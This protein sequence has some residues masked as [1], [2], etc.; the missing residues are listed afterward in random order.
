MWYGKHQGVDFAAQQDT[1][2]SA[3]DEGEVTD[4]NFYAWG[5]EV[6]V[7]MANG[8]TQRYLHMDSLGVH[9]GQHIGKGDYIG[10]TGGGTPHSGFGYWSRG[11]HLHT[12]FDEGNINQGIDPWS[13]WALMGTTN[14]SQYLGGTLSTA[15]KGTGGAANP[16][17]LATGGIA[18]RA[19]RAVVAE[20]NQP[21]AIIPLS[22]LSTV[23]AS[24][25]NMKPA[26]VNNQ[27]NLTLSI[28]NVNVTVEA[29]DGKIV[30]T[31]KAYATVIDLLSAA[32]TQVAQ[33]E[34]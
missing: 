28:G 8:L 2:L 13:I 1:V 11:S 33:K 32:L 17:F 16:T 30:D 4:A 14:I 29:K 23:A 25:M 7:Q 6:D 21:E 5:G 9:K 18:M 31:D 22:Q 27:R 12:Q 20:G 10:L 24:V 3:F 19:T 15:Q 34:S 26:S